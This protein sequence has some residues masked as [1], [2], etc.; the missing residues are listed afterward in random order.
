VI[1][2]LR[3]RLEVPRRLVHISGH[4]Q[5]LHDFSQRRVRRSALPDVVRDL[6][7]R[8]FPAIVAKQDNGFDDLLA[9]NLVLEDFAEEVKVDELVVA[10]EAL[11]LFGEELAG[12]QPVDVA[13]EG[14]GFGVVEDDAFGASPRVVEERFEDVG[15]GEGDDVAVDW[16][17][18]WMLG[19]VGADG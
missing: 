13:A 18:D 14:V 15:C 6:I 1:A 2:R 19:I 3:R 11:G 4:P 5:L 17:L 16:E 9:E 12:V 7:A 8:Q 10:C